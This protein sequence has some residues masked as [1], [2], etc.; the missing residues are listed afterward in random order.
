[1]VVFI[2]MQF[3]FSIGDYHLGGKILTVTVNYDIQT[4]QINFNTVFYV[5]EIKMIK[6][7]CNMRQWII[8]FLILFLII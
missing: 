7:K 2:Y 5:V 3:N 4:R 8:N 6:D 1:M